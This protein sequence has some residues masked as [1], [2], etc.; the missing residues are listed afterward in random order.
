MTN[1]INHIHSLLKMAHI[2]GK[3]KG[4][5]SFNSFPNLFF[6]F[7]FTNSINTRILARLKLPHNSFFGQ[8]WLNRD[9]SNPL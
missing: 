3:K 9:Q 2:K 5:I 8:K 7:I 1:Q 4:A 6:H